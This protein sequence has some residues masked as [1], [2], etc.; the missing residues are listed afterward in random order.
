MC[1]NS[2]SSSGAQT[3]V[4]LTGEVSKII[5][6]TVWQKNPRTIKNKS[7]SK[8]S[9]QY[10]HTLSGESDMCLGVY[11]N[12]SWQ[13]SKGRNWIHGSMFW[14]TKVS[15]ALWR[16][17]SVLWRVEQ[18][19][20]L[21]SFGFRRQGLTISARLALDLWRSSCLGFPSAEVTGRCQPTWLKEMHLKW[22]YLE[23]ASEDSSTQQLGIQL[24]G[25]GCLCSQSFL[26]V[27]EPTEQAF[28]L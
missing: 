6:S 16:P 17:L 25:L 15:M 9:P 20:G 2:N 8:D 11:T 3:G 12:Q 10:K 7:R 28:S 4:R 23:P 24:I 5:L 18:G 26:A 14:K 19:D 27:L 1:Y 22:P 13:H 21:F